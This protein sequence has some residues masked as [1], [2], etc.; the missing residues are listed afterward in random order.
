MENICDDMV[1]AM[2]LAESTT[3]VKGMLILQNSNVLWVIRLN[4]VSWP[5]L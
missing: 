4:Q 2:V 3:S 1:A 5:R